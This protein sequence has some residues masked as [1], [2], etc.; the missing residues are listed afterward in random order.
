MIEIHLFGTTGRSDAST[1]K[2]ASRDFCRSDR[3]QSEYGRMPRDGKSD[4]S[5]KICNIFIVLKVCPQPIAVP[6]A[7]RLTPGGGGLSGHPSHP[8]VDRHDASRRALTIG[9]AASCDRGWRTSMPPVNPSRSRAP[10]AS[11]RVLP[12]AAFRGTQVWAGHRSD[13]G[14]R[15]PT[16]GSIH[17]SACVSKARKSSSNCQ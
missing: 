1:I 13:R 15:A 16:M 5:C 10:G 9:Q 14:S 2:I 8:D 17:V 12:P 11:S 4:R 3:S 6:P 7:Q